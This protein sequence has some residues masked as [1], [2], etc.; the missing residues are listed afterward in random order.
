MSYAGELGPIELSAIKRYDPR[1]GW[2]VTRRFRGE[3]TLVAALAETHQLAGAGIEL[4]PEESGAYTTLNVTYGT[5]EAQ[6]H[7]EPLADQWVLAGND[8]EKSLWELPTVQATLRA[9]LPPG[10]S[11]SP[12]YL[13]A[14]KM[15]RDFRLSVDA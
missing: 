14:V 12:E 4:T 6:P 5:Q 2:S 7:D 10:S 9:T 3:S 8:I 15:R 13:A 1:T 11:D